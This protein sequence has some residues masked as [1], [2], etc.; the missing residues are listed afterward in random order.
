MGSGKTLVAFMAML[1]VVEAGGQ[2]ALMAPTGIL[3]QQH[4][5]SLQPLADLAGVELEILTGRD[6]GEVRARKLGRLAS[7]DTGMLV[8]THALFQRDVEFADLRLAII[9]EQHRFGVRQRMDLGGKGLAT[10][11][12]VMTANADP[13]LA[14]AQPV[15]RHG[16][17][18]AGR[19][20]AWPSAGGNGAGAGWAA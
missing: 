19:K 18:R 7:G 13:A 15:W 6:K 5:E 10:D 14:G 17:E 20:A 12:L 11:I 8:G 16:S 1:A 9:D 2:A 4:L 3:V